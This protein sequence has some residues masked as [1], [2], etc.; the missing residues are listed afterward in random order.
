[1]FWPTK[2]KDNFQLPPISRGTFSNAHA[3]PRG[4]SHTFIKMVFAYLTKNKLFAA[5]T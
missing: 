2:K 5:E 1:M 4:V 3:V